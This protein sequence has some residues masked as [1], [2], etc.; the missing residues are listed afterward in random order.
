[1]DLEI[2]WLGEESRRETE[3]VIAPLCIRTGWSLAPMILCES[4]ARS[5]FAL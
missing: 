1:M 2:G 5:E 4:K 3:G